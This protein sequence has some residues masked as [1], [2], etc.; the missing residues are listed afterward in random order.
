LALYKSFTYLLTYLLTQAQS[1]NRSFL[2]V[3]KNVAAADKMASVTV[4]RWN[5]NLDSVERRL[6]TTSN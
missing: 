6:Y 4:Y 5:L 2:L 1:K 3:A